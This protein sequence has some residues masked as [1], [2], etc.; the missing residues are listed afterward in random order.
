MTPI[1]E[2]D[3]AVTVDRDILPILSFEAKGNVIPR[4]YHGTGFLIADELLVTCWH[5]VRD[6][7]E[8]G[9]VYGV[10]IP[11]PN[12]GYTAL[13]LTDISR[14]KNGMDLATARVKLNQSLGLSLA[15]TKGRMAASDVWTFGHP[16]TSRNALD[17]G[18]V[19]FVLD[20]RYLEGY[21]SQESYQLN[22]YGKVPSYEIDMPA[23]KGLS[24]APLVLRQT[25]GVLGVI[26]GHVEYET[27]DSYRTLDPGTGKMVPEQVKVAHFAL[28]HHVSSLKRLSGKA[29][30]GKNLEDYL[31]GT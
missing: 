16:Y 6:K 23:P 28:A 9:L 7:L 27:I 17:S 11:K 13:Q 2:L 5:C 12:G 8:K 29:T 20:L 24:G 26:Y 1:V 10:A 18:E 3:G 15:E 19:S 22:E 31:K 25:T 30:G 14:D 4:A 21:I